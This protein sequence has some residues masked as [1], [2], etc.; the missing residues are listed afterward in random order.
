MILIKDNKMG[1]KYSS[2]QNKAKLANKDKLKKLGRMADE[3]RLRLHDS[4]QTRMLLTPRMARMRQSN[5]D[6]LAQAQSLKS[7]TPK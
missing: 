3:D 4:M 6:S 5:K 1:Q 7:T 2:E